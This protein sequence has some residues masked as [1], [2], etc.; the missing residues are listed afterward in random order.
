MNKL[1][2]YGTL[3]EVPIQEKLFSRILKGKKDS[4]TGF[5]KSNIHCLENIDGEEIYSTYPA[6]SKSGSNNEVLEG[7]L[8]ELTDKELKIADK[9]EGLE[10]QRISILT[11]NGHQAYVYI[12]KP[13]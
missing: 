5:R 8:Y 4:L 7:Y 1:F 11:N 6:I 2:A 13:D 10:Y 9:Y 12:K 3:L